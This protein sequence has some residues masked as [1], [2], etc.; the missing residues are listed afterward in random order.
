MENFTSSAAWWNRCEE[1]DIPLSG[2]NAWLC[3]WCFCCAA[4]FFDFPNSES[5][6]EIWKNMS[7]QMREKALAP[8][9]IK[10]YERGFKQAEWPLDSPYRIMAYL[11]KAPSSDS[12]LKHWMATASKIH[13]SRQWELPNFKHPL[14]QNFIDALKRRPSNSISCETN[15]ST[16]SESDLR[17]LFKC[18]KKNKQPTDRRNWAILV[19]QLFGVRR[20]SEVLS[21][22]TKDVKVVDNT[23]LL[24]VTSSK[25]DKRHKGLFYK[26]PCDCVFNFNP[27][28]V[29]A[30]HILS[31]KGNGFLIFQS[32]DPEKKKFLKKGIS[33]N[34]WNKALHRLCIRAGIT[35]K[36][37]HAVR[38]SAIT[39][40]PI[41]L[42]EAVAQTGGWRS[43][44]FWEVYRR[45]DIEQRAEATSKIGSRE[46][47]IQNNTIWMP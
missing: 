40:S 42:V 9:T 25:T 4:K 47:V 44:C 16:F 29:L 5:G 31:T 20:A 37:S 23:F 18:L 10:A 43:L 22:Q 26:L 30:K 1:C 35:P 28:E 19:V 6:K 41:H 14:V 46:K 33:V 15:T 8:S 12:S 39:L 21:L 7:Y 27:V 36:T 34:G 45:F 13:K 3:P 11:N 17:S 38:R 32:Y 2:K 24:K